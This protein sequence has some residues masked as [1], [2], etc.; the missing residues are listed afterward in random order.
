MKKERLIVDEVNVNNEQITIQCESM[1]LTRQKACEEIN[2]MFNLN[3][4]VKK[5]VNPERS[6]DN[7]TIH[8]GTTNTD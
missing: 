3:V 4:S 7:G 2:K 8:A 6:I 5:R 1:L